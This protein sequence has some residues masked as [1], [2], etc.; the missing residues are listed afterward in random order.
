[1]Y[2]LLNNFYGQLRGYDRWRIRRE[3]RRNETLSPEELSIQTR[4]LLEKR[5]HDAISRFPFYAIKAK[6]FRG[7]L[8]RDGDRVK[9]EELPIWTRADQ[10]G[11]FESINEPP[12]KSSFVNATGGSTGVPLEYYVTRRSWEWRTA[13]SDRGYSWAGAEA[14]VRSLYVWGTPIHAPGIVDKLRQ[15]FHHFLQKRTFFDSFHF[16]DEQK[17]LCCDAIN[18]LEPGA[19]VGYAGNLVEL[20]RFVRENDGCLTWHAGTII[21]A[22]E[23]L[24][25]G[26]RELLEEYLGEEV[27]MSYGSR[28]F[29]LIGMECRR[30]CGYHIASDNLFVE[31]V[32]DGGKPVEAEETGRILITDLR[33]GANPFVRYEI[34][35][36]G[37]LASRR[38]RCG[39]GLPFP[40]LARVDGRDQEVIYTP[41]GEKLTA[42][43]M[44][45]LMKEF[46]WVEGYQVVQD[47]KDSLVV[48]LVTREEPESRLTV[49]LETALREK[50]GPG[51][52]IGFER[53]ESLARNSTGKTPIVVS[54]VDRETSPYPRRKGKKEKK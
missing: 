25:P 50:V 44:P 7:T 54:S 12:V 16:G 31:A 21:T 22:A 42:L 32:D 13:V 49:A 17:R 36:L 8:P 45:H 15:G 43:F 48:R 52:E 2:R 23:G 3:V 1:M 4:T 6:E 27:F 41:D 38:R 39:C 5:V 14:G 29:M 30:H 40:I 9:L 35:D 53:V 33:N 19:L 28:E 18:R 47:R 11:F 51:M 20:A 46:R 37:A 24:H 10:R 26:Q 34:G